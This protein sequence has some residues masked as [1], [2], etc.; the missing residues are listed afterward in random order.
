MK[1]F[2]N[3]RSL[4]NEYPENSSEIIFGSGCFWGVERVFWGLSGVWVTY[5][6]Y[7]GGRRSSPNYE[8]V[9]TGVTGHAETVN[10]IYDSKEISTEQLLKVFWECHDPT[11]GNRQG[12]DIGTQY[13]SVIYCLNDKQLITARESKVKFNNELKQSG[14][15]EITTEIDINQ[16]CY[17]AEEYHQQYLAKNPNGYCGIKGTGC[18]LPPL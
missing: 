3:N 12:N 11:Q 17:A 18:M 6:S 15:S 4:F 13:R 9:C 2:V 8:Q 1:H 5:A 10:V 7:S 14:F 16:A